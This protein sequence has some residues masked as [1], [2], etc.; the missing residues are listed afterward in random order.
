MHS[1]MAGAVASEV[2]ANLTAQQSW[3]RSADRPVDPEAY[4]FWLKGNF[5]LS[6]LDENALKKAREFYEQAIQRDPNY[7]PAHAGLA[8]TWLE[9]G[10]WA[11]LG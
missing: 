9:A 5:L 2:R 11:W 1:E 4:Q 7:A 3:R 10:G 6:R 8:M